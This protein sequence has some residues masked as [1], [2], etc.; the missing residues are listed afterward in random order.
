MT[1]NKTPKDKMIDNLKINYE[2][3]LIKY[4][5]ERSYSENQIKNWID[6]ILSDAKVFSIKNYP[7]YDIFL[8]CFIAQ[9]NVYFNS[10]DK[11]ISKTKTDSSGVAL[12]ISENIF[13]EL[14]FF[15]F[16]H[17]TLDYSIN[18]FESD[19]IGKGNELIF[20]YLADRQKYNRGKNNDYIN[21]INNEHVDYIENLNSKLRCFVVSYIFQTP[22]FG[23]YYFNYI[24]HGKNI[25]KTLLQ[26]YQN[27]SLLMIHNIFFFK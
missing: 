19:I 12:F 22:L 5:N 17:Y 8:H 4:L 10:N 13:C 15:I 6:N 23:L 16:K 7:D 3:I 24:S 27:D 14:R 9:K 25:Y 20:K 18:S 21:K 26:S 1:T 2:Q 11:H